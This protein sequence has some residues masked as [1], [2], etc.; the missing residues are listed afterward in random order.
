MGV[1]MSE[2]VGPI[3]SPNQWQDSRACREGGWPESLVLESRRREPLAWVRDME[4]PE[5]GFDLT[6]QP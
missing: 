1:Y 2:R 4:S 5:W 6:H 3:R